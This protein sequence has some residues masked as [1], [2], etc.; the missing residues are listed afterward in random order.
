MKAPALDATGK[1]HGVLPRIQDLG[2]FSNS[3]LNNLAEYNYDAWR[4]M[5]N[6]QTLA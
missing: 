3:E 5:R 4:R 2:R 1:V 6:P